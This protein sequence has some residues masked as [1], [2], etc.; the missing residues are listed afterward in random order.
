MNALVSEL[1]IAAAQE[2]AKLDQC[3]ALL[4]STA[5]MQVRKNMRGCKTKLH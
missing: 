3:E 1:A 5:A 2:K 4:A